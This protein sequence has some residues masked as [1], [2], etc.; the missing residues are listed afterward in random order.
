MSAKLKRWLRTG[1]VLVVL[2]VASPVHAF[3][4][5]STGRWLS[6]D[7]IGERGGLNRYGFVA[8]NPV[9]NTDILGRLPFRKEV[10]LGIFTGELT[11]V[12]LA[13][14]TAKITFKP[15]D[16][17]CGCKKIR[18]VQIVKT[19]N[20]SGTQNHIW[21]DR[22]SPRNDVRTVTNGDSEGG[23]GVDFDPK[24]NRS[25]SP[26]YTDS[27]PKQDGN[28]EGSQNPGA[29]S[30]PAGLGDGPGRGGSENAE[31]FAFE[32]C[33]RCVPNSSD[34]S[35]GVYYGC[36]TWGFTA[37]KNR[38]AVMDPGAPAA[39]DGP[40]ATFLSAMSIF[41]GKYGAQ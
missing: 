20:L 16:L 18:L 10:S 13:T 14:V 32:T 22:D 17:G 37:Q 23:F 31:R 41:D 25:P 2:V 7:P 35:G 5:P 9:R 6:R 24:S 4:N 21:S 36:L 30:T 8:N 15:N 29:E 11:P 39:T 27:W 3:Y 38:I 19:T 26:Y 33:A 1:V 34:P 28:S 40:S 12:G